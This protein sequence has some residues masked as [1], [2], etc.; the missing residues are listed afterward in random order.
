MGNSQSNNSAYVWKLRRALPEDNRSGWY[1]T[2]GDDSDRTQFI[3]KQASH[4]QHRASH[5]KDGGLTLLLLCRGHDHSHNQQR[6]AQ[7][8][9]LRFQPDV[10][11]AR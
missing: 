10:L 1:G 2:N 4:T 5:P 8:A 9:G 11:S 7:S 6:P 3:R